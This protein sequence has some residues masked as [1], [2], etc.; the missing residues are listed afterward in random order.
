MFQCLFFLSLQKKK[1]KKKTCWKCST[2]GKKE[3]LFDIRARMTSSRSPVLFC[4]SEC[5]KSELSGPSLSLKLCHCFIQASRLCESTKAHRWE[6]S[7]LN[8]SAL[9]FLFFSGL[10]NTRRGRKK[11]KRAR[12]RKRTD[13]Y[14]VIAA[15]TLWE[16][17]RNYKTEVV[18]D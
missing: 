10:D 5:Y 6:P 13:I 8:L 7:A 14:T 3:K 16:R 1:K 4:V 9:P 2:A 17:L 12:D 18:H 11:K 15:A